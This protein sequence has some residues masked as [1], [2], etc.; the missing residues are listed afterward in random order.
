MSFHPAG[1]VPAGQGEDELEEQG[2]SQAQPKPQTPGR[3][4]RVSVALWGGRP[5]MEPQPYPC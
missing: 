1:A 3:W 4:D 5:G 2:Q